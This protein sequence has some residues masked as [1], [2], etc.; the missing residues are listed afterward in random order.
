M[1]DEENKQKW[2]ISLLSGIVFC[3]IASQKMYKFTGKILK[4]FTDEKVE[5]NGKPT[6]FGL[7]VHTIVFILLTRF[8]MDLNLFK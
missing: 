1:I 2:F 6:K 5:I 8:L 3:L 4:N 7:L